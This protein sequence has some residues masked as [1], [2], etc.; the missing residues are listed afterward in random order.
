MAYRFCDHSSSK[1]Q[2]Q[3]T[4]EP[5]NPSP[6]LFMG[7]RVLLLCNVHQVFFVCQQVRFETGLSTESD[8]IVKRSIR[9]LGLTGR[10]QRFPR[11]I[12]FSGCWDIHIRV[13]CA[14]A[15]SR[16]SSRNLSAVSCGMS[17]GLMVL[18]IKVTRWIPGS[19]QTQQT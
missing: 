12:S 4:T 13:L 8:P 17:V 7:L 6:P 18:W 15:F 16:H 1:T 19:R 14:N 2:V 11:P 10:G 9:C 5:F 3:I